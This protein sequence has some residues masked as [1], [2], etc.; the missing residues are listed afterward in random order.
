MM[1][2]SFSMVTYLAL[3][4]RWLSSFLLQ[5]TQLAF[6]QIWKSAA[7]A[8]TVFNC[9]VFT[10][11]TSSLQWWSSG[12]QRSRIH[13]LH[14][15]CDDGYQFFKGSCNWR[16]LHGD[17]VQFF[18]DHAFDMVPVV[19]IP[20]SSGGMLLAL[21][22]RW[23]LSVLSDGTLCGWQEVKIQSLANCRFS[24]VTR[25]ALPLWW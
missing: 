9:S 12:L 6:S 22:L 8:V 24:A 25:L 10:H 7:L 20:S 11:L 13:S 17:G 18:S 3:C 2:L 1:V 19:V 4:L 5:A 15:I 23:W 21:C 14:C 16:C